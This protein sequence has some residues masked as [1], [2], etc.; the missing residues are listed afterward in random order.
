MYR[1]TRNRINIVTSK[2]VKLKIYDLKIKPEYFAITYHKFK[3]ILH[4]I[5]YYS[6]N[7]IIV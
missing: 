4:I 1:Q 2:S 5:L 7:I 6:I 3:S